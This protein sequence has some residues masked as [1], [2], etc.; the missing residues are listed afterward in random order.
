MIFVVAANFRVKKLAAACVQ[1]IA[2]CGYRWIAFDLGGLG[3]GRAFRVSDQM[4]HWKGHY[5]THFTKWPSRAIHK[6]EVI[7]AAMQEFNEPLV[8]LDADTL[9]R[10]RVD[11]LC[12]TFDVG[13]TIRRPIEQSIHGRINAGVLFFNATPQAKEL[14][15]TWRQVT[16]EIGNDQEALSTLLTDSRWRVSEFPCDVYNWYYYPDKPPPTA[17]ILHLKVSRLE[18]NRVPA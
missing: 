15:Q 18:F 1:S 10:Q 14:V 17:K 12:G 3:F 6:P 8:Y 9:L 11:E 4:F 13:V 7:A 5:E 2:T 16:Q